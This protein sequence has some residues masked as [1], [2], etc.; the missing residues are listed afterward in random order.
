MGLEEYGE[1]SGIWI[2]DP[3]WP[4][5]EEHPPM[6]LIGAG[7]PNL[8]TL[9][10]VSDVNGR[11]VTRYMS[12]G[13]LV[14]KSVIWAIPCLG[15]DQRQR[16]WRWRMDKCRFLRIRF[17]DVWVPLVPSSFH[18]LTTL[19]FDVWRATNFIS[20]GLM[21]GET[22]SETAKWLSSDDAAP[23]PQFV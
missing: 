3:T 21:V 5:R 2:P 12:Y 14:L 7:R 19:G 13:Y 23:R 15:D 6:A 4:R 10:Q 22:F 11:P 18:M 16:S 1:L 8:I 17:D 20:I 9:H